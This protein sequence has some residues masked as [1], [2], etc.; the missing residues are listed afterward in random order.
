MEFRKS[1]AAQ[2]PEEPSER[3][4]DTWPEGMR[5]EPKSEDAKSGVQ[6]TRKDRFWV[7]VLTGGTAGVIYRLE[8]D[9]LVIGRGA[10]ATARLDVDSLSRKHARLFR[11]GDVVFVEDL[12]SANGTYVNGERVTE[13][14]R[15]DD[16][17]RVELGRSV[18]LRVSLQDVL[19][20][21]TV[22]R[23]YNSSVR[24]QLTGL[25]NRHYFDDRLIGEYSFARRNDTQL[26]IFLIDVDHFRRINQEHGTA[27]GDAVLRVLGTAFT[28]ITRQEDVLARYEGEQFVMLARA[29]TQRNAGILAERLRRHAEG[30]RLPV[31]GQELALTVSVGVATHCEERQFPSGQAL[32]QAAQLALQA[33]KKAGRNRIAGT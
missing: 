9:E 11:R 21:E 26:S 6:S 14:T 27:T 23:F 2:T 13:P 8:N 24:D 18:I 29:L 28:R 15:L 25:Y 4:R 16:G 3:R 19:E 7:T 22:V 32:V 17:D 33:A 12:Q 10:A 20:E 31:T 1:P 30:L 5:E